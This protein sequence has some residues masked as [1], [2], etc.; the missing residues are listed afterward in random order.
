[1]YI[2]CC[3]MANVTLKMVIYYMFTLVRF[4]TYKANLTFDVK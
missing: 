4:Q 1:M 2:G 3:E